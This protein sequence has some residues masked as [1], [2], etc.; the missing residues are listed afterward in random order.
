[1]SDITLELFEPH[2]GSTFQIVL[3]GQP[4]LDLTL[5]E[6]EDLT[7]KD[8]LRSPAVRERSFSLIFHG[9]ASPVYR[10]A[11]YEVSHAELGGLQIFLVPI[12]P[13]TQARDKMRYQAIYN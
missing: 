6:L 10:Q 5:A 2:V 11:N 13:D 1:M 9:P 3:D 8:R 12:G 4:V 7:V